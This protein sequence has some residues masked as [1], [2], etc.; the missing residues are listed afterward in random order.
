[1]SGAT[2]RPLEGRVAL[3]T[4]A[5]TRVGRAIALELGRKGA[6]VAV[7]HWT[8]EAGA[9]TACDAIRVDGNR[10]AAL[11]ADLS[12]E[13]A[14]KGLVARAQAELGPLS[15]LVNSAAVWGPKYSPDDFWKVNAKAPYLL[16]LAFAEAAIGPSDV[17][18]ILDIGGVLNTWRAELPYTMSKAAAAAA[19]KAFAVKLAPKIRVNAVAPGVVLPPEGTPAENIEALRQKIPQQRIGSAQDVA[20][21]VALLL[22]G[23]TFMTG[24]VLAVDGGRSL[25]L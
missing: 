4:G 3:V 12:D 5:G 8:S 15:I 14:A 6:H 25:A 19:T 18:N 9:Q 23:P 16:T 2:V 24:Q 17:V 21:A 22:L 11:K 13:S 1:M 10:A 20:D 7:H